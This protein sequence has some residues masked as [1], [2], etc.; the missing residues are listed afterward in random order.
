MVGDREHDIIGAQEC[1]IASMSVLYGYGSR[2]E[3]QQAGA[4]FMAESVSAVG[5]QLLSL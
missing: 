5:T 2:D 3:L 1:G 4:D